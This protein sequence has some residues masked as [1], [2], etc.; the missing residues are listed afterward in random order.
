MSAR[1]AETLREHRHC[2][3][4][5]S[6]LTLLLTF[7]TIL[8]SFRGDVFWLPT[9]GST[10]TFIK[11]WDIWYGGQFF[12]GAADRFYTDL[13]FYPDGVALTY[14]PLLLP[15]VLFV[16]A[17]QP[18]LPLANAYSLSYLVMIW[19][20]ALAAYIYFLYLFQEKWLALFGAALFGFSPHVVGHPNHPDIMFMATLP[21]TLYCLQRGLKEGRAAL[22]AL[23][24]VF[25]GLTTVISMYAYICLIIT[26]GLMVG[27]LTVSRWRERGYWRLLIVFCL[28][29]ALASAWRVLP[30]LADANALD[31]AAAWHGAGERKYDLIS[32]FVN[33]RHPLIGPLGQSLLATPGNTRTSDTSY[34]GY[35]ALTLIAMALISKSSR[36]KTLPW[37]ALAAPFLVLRLGSILSIN[38][39][40]FPEYPLPK[41]YLDQL[42]PFF[43]ETFRETDN[44]MMGVILPLAVAATFGLMALR[45]KLP[46]ARRPW[47][48]LL[49]IAMV[50]FEFYMP[51]EERVIP[52]EQ[53][54][55][56]D[57]L[58]A[59]PDQE[60]A[61]IN[62]PMG[63][64]NSK[65][66]NLFQALSG[67]PHAEGAISRTPDSAFDYIRANY[68]LSAWQKAEPASCELRNREEYLA[69]IEQLYND[70]FSHVVFYRD[71]YYAQDI[72]PSF[73]N[74]TAAYSDDFVSIYRLQ[75]LRESCPQA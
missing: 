45:R 69:G 53:F 30:M 29:A 68:L 24:G 28:V 57:W 31:A 67:Y 36:L 65:Y 10:D 27:A 15:Q 7:P 44:F 71:L 32:Y 66:Y 52:Q 2:L 37:V 64:G 61:L 54:A 9:G 43:F 12:S 75:A 1:I 73:R 38:R 74:A 51:I 50:A 8:Y 47:F 49:L 3:L 6:A 19:L 70:G 40:H 58:A 5:V 20:T 48:T 21:A 23:A 25:A 22:V 4:V 63:R 41:F 56:I 42:L 35:V 17:L 34:L 60:I 13:M 11:I 14:H 59:E 26:L 18:L 72:E 33:H 55:F 16:N 62:L 46:L 39:V